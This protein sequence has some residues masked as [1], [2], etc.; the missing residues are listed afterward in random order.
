MVTRVG[1]ARRSLRRRG[2]LPLPR[3]A[4]LCSAHHL[5]AARMRVASFGALVPSFG[6][7]VPSFGA[8]VPSF[9]VRVVELRRASSSF[10]GRRRASAGAAWAPSPA[11]GGLAPRPGLRGPARAAAQRAASTHGVPRRS[12]Q[13]ATLTR[14]FEFFSSPEAEARPIRLLWRLWL[15]QRARSPPARRTCHGSTRMASTDALGLRSSVCV[16]RRAA[17]ASH[18]PSRSDA[19][20]TR[21]EEFCPPSGKRVQISGTGS[22][23]AAVC[24][25]W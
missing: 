6:A 24:R 1:T 5:S 11:R 22:S 20:R 17:E 13:G 23:S 7:L 8:L 14:S 25:N 4:P 16:A 15:A 9:G 3:A 21:S 10:D 18:L 12:A 19:I 2:L